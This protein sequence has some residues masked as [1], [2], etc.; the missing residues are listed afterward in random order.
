MAQDVCSSHSD[1]VTRK[2]ARD[3]HGHVV[4]VMDVIPFNG[5]IVRQ[6]FYETF[7]LPPDSVQ[8]QNLADGNSA[9]SQLEPSATG[10]AG[11]T[12][13]LECLAVDKKVWNSRCQEHVTWTYAKVV[14]N[15]GEIG[16][17]II[18]IRGSCSCAV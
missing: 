1:W 2:E 7:C 4:E 8:Q 13:Q 6:Y 18:A 17:G 16:W 5:T 10:K 9:S 14:K 15:T 12:S 11:D 3:I